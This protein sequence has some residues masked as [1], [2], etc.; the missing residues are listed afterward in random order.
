MRGY[1][2]DEGFLGVMDERVAQNYYDHVLTYG[3]GGYFSGSMALSW[4]TRQSLKLGER[5][6]TLIPAAGPDDLAGSH[7]TVHNFVLDE[8]QHPVLG[9]DVYFVGEDLPVKGVDVVTLA[10]LKDCT[11]RWQEMTPQDLTVARLPKKLPHRETLAHAF[12]HTSL[13]AFQEKFKFDKRLLPPFWYTLLVGTNENVSFFE[14]YGH[15]TPSDWEMAVFERANRTAFLHHTALQGRLLKEVSRHVFVEERPKILDILMGR[16]RSSKFVLWPFLLTVR[17]YVLE[18]SRVWPHLSI[19]R[20]KVA[21]WL[22]LV[23]AYPVGA[24]RDWGQP[25]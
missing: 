14:T 5:M 10:W 20:E 2:V 25:R 24:L 8:E 15:F 23:N 3:K 12:T 17:A 16:K 11:R 6:M 4:L 13:G 7:Q 21:F 19:H 22:A 18:H 1:G 9:R